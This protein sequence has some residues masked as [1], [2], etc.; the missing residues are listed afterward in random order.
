[1][2]MACSKKPKAALDGMLRFSSRRSAMAS[3][4]S[5]CKA[6]AFCDDEDAT[7]AFFTATDLEDDS[8]KAGVGFEKSAVGYLVDD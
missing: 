3:C 8:T 6:A 7:S 5:A 4:L 2:T 1:M